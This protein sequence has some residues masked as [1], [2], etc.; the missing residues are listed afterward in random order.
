MESRKGW[1]SSTI[2]I[3]LGFGI[4]APGSFSAPATGAA[5]TPCK[6]LAIS[7]K[8]RDEAMAAPLDDGLSPS[9]IGLGLGKWAVHVDGL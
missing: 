3:N 2:E 4:A 8:V 1:S 9:A 5:Q 6:Q 7:V